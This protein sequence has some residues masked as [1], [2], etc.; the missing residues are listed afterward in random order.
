MKCDSR[1]KLRVCSEPA[2][3]VRNA[4][5]LQAALVTRVGGKQAKEGGELNHFSNSE[6]A[7]E[8]VQGLWSFQAPRSRKPAAKRTCSTWTDCSHFIAEARKSQQG[9]PYSHGQGQKRNASVSARRLASRKDA[10]Q[11]LSQHASDLN[12]KQHEFVVRH[13]DRYFT[14]VD[15]EFVSL[16]SVT[17]PSYLLLH[18]PPGTGKSKV[19]Y[20]LK[21]FFTEVAK[22]RLGLE[23]GVASLQAV[24]A[25][26]L[27][28]ETLH[29]VTGMRAFKRTGVPAASDNRNENVSARLSFMRNLLIDELFMISAALAAEAELEVRQ[30]V[31]DTCF[32]KRDVAGNVRPWGGLN[33]TY[34][35]DVYQ[36]DP[37]EG[38]PLYTVPSEFI[39]GDAEPPSNPLVT[40]GL[41]L[42][43]GTMEQPAVEL[44]E[45]EE[46]FRCKD[47]WWNSAPWLC[48]RT[49]R[50]ACSSNYCS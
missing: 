6:A 20:V 12:P 25:A 39:S 44:T 24:V 41:Q 5:S 9:D 47:A 2:C 42:F 31:P 38:L 11:W 1:P 28:G 33:M 10:D 48:F 27:G 26:M 29:H 36:I 34:F 13:V 8:H 32:F 46:P 4:A 37:P 14:E 7:I 22:Y 3:D 43:W 30:R 16:A 40:R 23:L 21:R 50:A 17:E 15:E 19:I 35:G 45:L 18:G 49:F